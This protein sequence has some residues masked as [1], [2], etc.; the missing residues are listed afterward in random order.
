MTVI[1]VMKDDNDKLTWPREQLILCPPPFND[2]ADLE[3]KRGV[4]DK[5]E[6]ICKMR[7]IYH[8][9][10][11]WSHVESKHEG[12]GILLQVDTDVEPHLERSFE[13]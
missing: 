5:Y 11:V 8:C 6:K 3:T 12:E 7:L 9:N 4:S 13:F 10:H 2:Q 1:T